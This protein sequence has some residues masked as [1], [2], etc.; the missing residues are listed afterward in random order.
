MQQLYPGV[1]LISLVLLFSACTGNQEEPASPAFMPEVLDSDLQ[2]ELIATSPSIMTPIGLAIDSKDNIY[3]LESH[4]HSPPSDYTGPQFDRI[5]KGVDANQ[6]GRPESWI[7][8]ADSINDG[9]NLA[10]GPDDVVYLTE[11]DRVLVFQDTDGDGVS[12]ERNTILQMNTPKDVYDHAGILGITYGPDGWLYV[13]RGNCASLAYEI[14]GTDG[15]S[16]QGYGDGGN[17]FRCRPDGSAVEEIATGFWN[18]FDLKFSR[19]GRL[20]LVDN[21]PDSRGPNRLLEIVPGGDYGYQSLYGGSGIH[22]FLAWNGELPG[23]LPYA[24][25]LGEAPSGLIDASFTNF[26]A[27]YENN[28]LATIWEENNIVR[29]PLKQYQRSVTG[30]TEVIVQGDSTFHPVAL[31]ANSRGEV[32]ITDWV[33]RQYPNHGEGR[34]W[35]LTSG[36]Q[37]PLATASVQTVDYD[38]G[39][40]N[41]FSLF[42]NLQGFDQHLRA[43]QTDDPFL[44]AVARKSLSQDT[45]Y[46]QDVLRLI[47]E[48]NAGMRLQALLTLSE[49]S[50]IL[51]KDRLKTLLQDESED[52]RRMTLIY[53]A[54]HARAELL[55]EVSKALKNGHITPALFETYLATMRHLQP[56]F[57]RDHQTKT[58]AEAKQI[59]RELP[60]DYL[61]SIVR[62]QRLSPEIRAVALPY[63]ESPGENVEPLVAM[64]KSAAPPLQMALLHS[65]KQTNEEE[66]ADAM[67][68]IVLD[69]DAATDLRTQAL[70]SLSYQSTAYCKEVQPLLQEEDE[71]LLET[72]VRYLC[73]CGGNQA[74][75]QA[76]PQLIAESSHQH[77]DQLQQIWQLCRSTLAAE[78]RPS[79]D[80]A[81]AQAVDDSGDPEKGKLIFQLP[82]TQCQRCHKVEGWGGDFGPAL[83]NVGSS[84]NKEQLISA[85]LE[86]SAAISPEWQG[87]YVTDSTGQTHYGRQI[88]LGY[89]SAELLMPTGSFV[90][91]KAPK[92]YGVAPTSLMPEGLENTLTA[93]EF[94]HLIAYLMSLK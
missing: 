85:I 69:N 14:T 58:E 72:S 11:K 54:T 94:N 60:P 28:I 70:V 8:F 66:V 38:K 7:I 49:S 83:S 16:I 39:E 32:Y 30:T 26:P 36:G 92:K 17:V 57:I 18:P 15:S 53:I 65:L 52:I 67:L 77:K 75:S 88:D 6:D 78:D 5:K 9:M 37:E 10:I 42:A 3:F 40:D 44:Q 93:S 12:D 68:V 21:D 50:E 76:V 22:P 63:L 64:L 48:E 51:S 62:D 74:V 46:Y 23:T 55:P 71:R 31:A 13:S 35:R 1:F 33:V 34:I 4:T 84:K 56:N 2:M 41:P 43:L 25:A 19:Q 82:G 29:V 24:A 80:E 59:K 47:D 91:F 89:N 79:S 61:L 86:P 81:W 87:W 27:A 90:T 20:M 45:S 73:R